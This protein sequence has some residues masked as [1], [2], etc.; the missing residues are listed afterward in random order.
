MDQQ[1]LNRLASL[2][3][4]K[5][6]LYESNKFFKLESVNNFFNQVRYV[7]DINTWNKKDYWASRDE[8]LEKGQGDCEDFAIAKYTT[9]KELGVADI[10]LTF[11]IVIKTDERH[12]VASHLT[13]YNQLLILDNYNKEMKFVNDR[14]DIAC[15]YTFN[16]YKLFLNKNDT[17]GDRVDRTIGHQLKL[18]ELTNEL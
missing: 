3:N 7:S 10:Y 9:L 17:L 16:E 8:F 1:A 12:L 11:C 2:H 13:R 14:K 4:L 6:S 15:V 18:R 5:N